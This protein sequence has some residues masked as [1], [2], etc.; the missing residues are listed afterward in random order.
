MNI[1]KE[2]MFDR[3]PITTNPAPEIPSGTNGETG[4]QVNWGLI[5]VLVVLSG[6][7]VGYGIKSY[8]DSR[9]KEKRYSNL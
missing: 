3:P 5:I 6:I 9:E 1:Q 4:N 8:I 2:G 7:L